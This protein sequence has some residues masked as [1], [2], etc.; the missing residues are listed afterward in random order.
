M[1][2]E[3]HLLLITHHLEMDVEMETTRQAATSGQG[4]LVRVAAAQTSPEIG[5][6]ERNLEE[7]LEYLGEASSEGAGLVVF[8]ECALSGYV[9]EDPGEL[10]LLAEPMDGPVI[11]R[12]AEA[13]GRRRV[14]AVVGFLER[15]SD[16][17]YNAALVAG[18]GGVL[19]RYRKAHLPGLGLDRF[20]SPGNTPFAVYETEVGRVGVSICYD[21]RFPEVARVLAL[22]GADIVAIPSNWP[23]VEGVAPPSSIPEVLTRAR[24]LE[25]R[26]FLAV[27]DRV[28]V[29]RGWGF[30]GRSQLVNALGAVVAEAGPRSTE[31]IYAD[32]DLAVARQKDFVYIPDR[33]ETHWFRD[34]RT[35]LYGPLLEPS[36]ERDREAA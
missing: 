3:W 30:I 8:P 9:V 20:V 4:P 13:C 34:R 23:T 35:D 17:I 31:I 19:G 5:A 10:A 14:Y 18:P 21:V 7:V 26:V 11:Q 2:D 25:N 15:G 22:R 6:T 29:E 27:A 12:L 1:S 28:G 32:F 16:G 24:A 33:F 36:A